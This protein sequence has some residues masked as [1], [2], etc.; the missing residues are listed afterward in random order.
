MAPWEHKNLLCSNQFF[1]LDGDV[2]RLQYH[3]RVFSLISCAFGV[4]LGRW[5]VRR[6]QCYYQDVLI[7]ATVA[8][9]RFFFFSVVKA[10]HL[11]RKLKT[12]ISPKLIWLKL[13]LLPDAIF[14]Y[15]AIGVQRESQQQPKIL[16]FP[17]I[18]GY[19]APSFRKHFRQKEVYLSTISDDCGLRIPVIQ[20][21]FSPK[22]GIP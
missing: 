7:H 20:K 19:G 3:F 4:G 1:A 5:R 13:K 18:L 2:G 22:R 16:W 6:F 14:L 21:T 8:V 9:H 15:G 12:Y 10:P 17:T 11:R